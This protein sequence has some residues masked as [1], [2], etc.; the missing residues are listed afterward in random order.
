[1]LE[2]LAFAA[3]AVLSFLLAVRCLRQQE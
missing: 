3:F 1:L 2:A